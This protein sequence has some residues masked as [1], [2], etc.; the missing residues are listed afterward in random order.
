MLERERRAP[1]GFPLFPPDQ[2]EINIIGENYESE[3]KVL[4]DYVLGTKHFL[5]CVL[6]MS[7]G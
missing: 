6:D 7:V 3:G 5:H 4:M 2:P 1:K